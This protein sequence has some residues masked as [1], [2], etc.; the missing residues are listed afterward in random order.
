VAHY[1]VL[2]W[3]DI[4]SLVEATDAAETVQVALSP[5][6]QDLIDAVAVRDGATESD[7]YLEG[8]AHGPPAERPGTAREVADR[9]AAELEQAFP[10]LVARVMGR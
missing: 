10:E 4:P 7:A 6:F 3:R 1:R 8:W 2:G 5:K 9:V